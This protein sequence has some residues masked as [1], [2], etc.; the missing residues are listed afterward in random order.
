MNYFVQSSEN[1]AQQKLILTD[2]KCQ[3]FEDGFIINRQQM[4]DILNN[5]QCKE[6]L[7]VIFFHHH[8]PDVKVR[9]LN[10]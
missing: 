9:M 6:N 10:Q 5:K 2:K 8:N 7:L 1:L 3:F 4:M